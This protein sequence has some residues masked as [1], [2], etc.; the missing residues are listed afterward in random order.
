MSAGLLIERVRCAVGAN[1]ED[2]AVKVKKALQT[3]VSTAICVRTR[4]TSAV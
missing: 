4:S 2:R 1:G 3:L